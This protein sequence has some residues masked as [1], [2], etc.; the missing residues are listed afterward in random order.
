MTDTLAARRFVTLHA[1]LIDRRRM[2]GDPALIRS[3]LAAYRNPDGGFGYLEPDLPDPGSQ[4]I[5]AL[6]ALEV[7]HETYARPDDPLMVDLARWLETVTGPD[8]G[9]DFVLPYDATAIP[10]APWMTP[11]D[12]RTSSLHMTAAVAAAAHRAGMAAGPGRR[13]LDRA[14][15]FV[16][17]RLDD[18]GP[19]PGYETK[20]VIDFLDAVSDRDR[21]DRALDA[22]ARTLESRQH[23]AV[24]G[25]TEGEVL[26]A[27]TIA[28]RPDHA[29]RRLFDQAA[30][31]RQ[32]DE[33][34]DGQQADGGWTF[35]WLAWDDA[36]AWAWRGKLTVDA[37]R[38]L[39]ANGR[40]A[41]VPG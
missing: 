27:L 15:A 16:W 26:T 8:G 25:G 33:L 40:L 37:L 13:W 3:A 29:G 32:L 35:D 5:T 22:V 6:G 1:R 28:P 18:L 34:A 4:P 21:A 20:Y 30:V 23:I 24:A 11:P 36:V 7:L 17:S 2:D 19:R 31:E 39:A 38:T 14:S 10:H 41:A 12:E 9:L